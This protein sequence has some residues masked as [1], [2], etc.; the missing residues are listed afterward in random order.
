MAEN[1]NEVRRAELG[2]YDRLRAG[3]SSISAFVLRVVLADNEIVHFKFGKQLATACK[4]SERARQKRGT[5]H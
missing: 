3:E 4:G 5:H 1:H 2:S